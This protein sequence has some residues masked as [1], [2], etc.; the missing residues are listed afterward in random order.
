MADTQK[1]K[2]RHRWRTC[3]VVA[4]FTV[5]V[6]V[7]L[8]VFA[9]VLFSSLIRMVDR[10]SAETIS[11]EVEMRYERMKADGKIPAGQGALF[12]DIFALSQRDTA[13]LWAVLLCRAVLDDSL[14]D[15]Q[16]SSREI[17]RAGDAIK[18]L[19]RQ[20]ALSRPDLDLFLRD[21]PELEP[22][23]RQFLLRPFEAADGGTIGEET[24]AALP[25]PPP[26]AK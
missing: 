18:L 2:R 26:P 5:G 16:V 21:Y 14:V 3:G 25:P 12:A 8:G 20:I 4:A 17:R 22:P 19:D 24:R 7:L 11:A 9:A 15:G 6:L 23:I 10:I 13:S 1:P